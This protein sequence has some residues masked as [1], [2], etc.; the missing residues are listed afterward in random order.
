MFQHSTIIT[1]ITIINTCDKS[2]LVSTLI[3]FTKLPWCIYFIFSQLLITIIITSITKTCDKSRPVSRLILS[4]ISSHHPLHIVWKHTLGILLYSLCFLKT[5]LLSF[6]FGMTVISHGPFPIQHSPSQLV[7][8][9]NW[10]PQTTQNSQKFIKCLRHLSNPSFSPSSFV[11]IFRLVV[12]RLSRLSSNI[13]MFH[14]CR[15]SPL[16]AGTEDRCWSWSLF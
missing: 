3:L 13:P 6:L 8:P 14:P 12:L 2:C 5:S 16:P 9:F 11:L 7:L 10:S 1:T 4:T 15:R